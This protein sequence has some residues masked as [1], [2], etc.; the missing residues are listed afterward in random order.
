M[1]YNPLELEPEILEFWQKNQ[2][3]KKVKDK[4][5]G[6]KKFYF[7][8]GPPYTS[9]KVHI[10][11]G[12]NKSLKDCFL[13]YKRM[14][15]I[16]IWDRAGYDM[17]GL[18]TANAV[19]KKL[20][21]EHKEDI[22][23]FGMEKFVG[24][25]KQL[26]TDNMKAMNKDFG[27][28]GVWM[29][30]ENAYQ[31]IKKEFIEAEWWL[32]KKA[33]EN[34][35]LYEALKTMTWCRHCATALAKHEL[36]YKTVNDTSIFLKFPVIGNEKEFLIIWTTTPWT[37]PYNLGVMV[38]PGLDYV[39]AQVGDEVWILSKALVG[40]L[41]ANLTD[42]TYKVLE[43]FK[44]E[45][46]EGLE[47]KHPFQ[48]EIDYKE[49]KNKHPNVHT[50]VMSSEY[51]DTTAGSGLVHLAPGCGPEDYEVGH[52]NQIPPFNNLS[53]TGVFPNSMG[54]FSGLVAK[55][56]DAEFIKAL[57]EAGAL[58]AQTKIDHDY[59]HCW[60]CHQP[61][62]YKTTKQWFFKIE[63]LIP[64]LR[65]INKN[66]TWVPKWAGDRQFDSWLA[67]LRDNSITRQRYWGTPLPIWR[68]DKCKRYQ[69]IG[70]VLELKQK[71]TNEVPEDLHKPLIDEVKIKCNCGNN[72]IRIPD[73]LDVWVD[74]GTTSWTCL[75]YPQEKELFK[76]LF[77]AEFILEAKDQIR[78][79]FNILLVCSM[80]AMEKP[81]YKAVYMHGWAVDLQGRKMSKSLGNYILPKEVIDKYGA[82]T[83]R[84]YMI[85]G[86]VPGVDLNYNF[87]DMKIKYRNLFILW[88][89]HKFII[90]LSK[91]LKINPAKSSKAMEDLFS[92]EEKYIISKL[93]SS[94]KNV[95]ELYEKYK[96]N[97][98]PWSIEALFLELSRTYIQLVR[99]KSSIGTPKEREVVLYTIYKVLLDCLKMFSTIAPF[100]CEKIYQNFK[101]EF[102]LECES[103]HLCE[104]PKHNESLIDKKLEDKMDIAKS[105][106][107]AG[108]NAREKSKL[109]LRWPIPWL[110][111][112]TSNE[113]V[114]QTIRTLVDIIKTQVN[115]KEIGITQK[116][117]N[118]KLSIKA[119]Y[120]KL[121][122]EFKQD[123]TKIISKLT[124]LSAESILAKLQSQGKFVIT[125]KDKSF[126]IKKDHILVEREIPVKFKESE[127]RHGIVYIDR[128]LTDDLEAEGFARE[129]MRRVQQLRKKNG[130]QK[131]DKIGLV[132][133]VD[134][135]LSKALDIHEKLI[136]AKTGAELIKI[137]QLEPT[138]K[139]DIHSKEQIREK[140][141]EIWFKKM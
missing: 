14:N 12:M 141:I 28:L 129:I 79:W 118:V 109:G 67:N 80:V 56:D 64:N 124:S 89:I 75:N 81:S 88:N 68:C 133:K 4:N 38:N 77:P 35:R 111:V 130:L 123:T 126:D 32:V 106:I 63:D 2:I 96:L 122:P 87:E 115:V 59:A 138:K 99:D 71:A 8:D 86:S 102:S 15:N 66:V 90:N 137:S 24:E 7:L 25:C 103:I 54:K 128:D 110:Y 95:T 136:K 73:I 62:I 121:A 55:K 9:G 101:S 119:N 48:G 29:G 21:L 50:V 57:D 6:K 135:E 47:Y 49:L 31:S 92:I 97:E 84:Y 60:R 140:D 94:I 70:S 116:M 41:I 85:G 112:E 45:Q 61:V 74:A 58:L 104:W 27:R 108:L 139:L 23:K 20:G 39:K 5:L 10:G 53:E 134:E 65:E 113:D 91:E 30:F 117:P 44:G 131:T 43:E 13:R 40:M 52:R 93:N 16:D 42:K 125:M 3:Y 11:T 100:I 17:H 1:K 36:E 34:K 78:G 107:Q 26:C 82:D 69:V 19:M 127:F 46:L 114:K 72:M 83:F 105:I 120:P 22:L 76:E 51:V 98:V 132:I 18:P 37:I 33:H